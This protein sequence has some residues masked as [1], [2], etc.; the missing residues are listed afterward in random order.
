MQ[1]HKI[2]V[3][4]KGKFVLTNNVS[5]HD[6]EFPRLVDKFKIAE[7]CGFPNST[8]G[9][10]SAGG[11]YYSLTSNVSK[12]LSLSPDKQGYECLFKDGKIRTISSSFFVQG[13]QKM[14]SEE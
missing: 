13:I 3:P 1:C 5:F 12:I 8:A 10:S 11:G 4:S 7:D 2:W 9:S 6:L 14:A